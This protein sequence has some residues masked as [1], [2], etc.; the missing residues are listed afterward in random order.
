MLFY[1]VA[2][3]KLNVRATWLT[4]TLGELAYP[5]YLF[6]I[7]FLFFYWY[8][9]DIVN[10]ELLIAGIF[11]M[12]L[13]FSYIINILIEKPLTKITAF[14]MNTLLDLFNESKLSRS[15]PETIHNEK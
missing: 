3:G 1:L 7:Y 5:I 10:G 12:I 15:G 14:T 11:I 4:T 9:R 8:F 13:L 6:H 2:R